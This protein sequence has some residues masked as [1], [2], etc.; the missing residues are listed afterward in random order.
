MDEP[1]TELENNFISCAPETCKKVPL[2][3]GLKNS[4]RWLLIFVLLTFVCILPVINIILF[5]FLLV[6]VPGIMIISNRILCRGLDARKRIKLGEPEYRDEDYAKPSIVLGFVMLTTVVVALAS[7]FLFGPFLK[8]FPG[9]GAYRIQQN[10]EDY[11]ELHDGK[12]PSVENWCDELRQMGIDEQ[13]KEG[14]GEYSEYSLL[15]GKD[16]LVYYGMN[17]NVKGL[18]E[19]PADMVVFFECEPGWNVHGN[20]EQVVNRWG[21]RVGVIFGDCSDEIYRAKDVP[22]LKWRPGDS[23]MIPQT[24]RII[25]YAVLGSGVAAITFWLLFKYRAGFKKYWWLSIAMSGIAVV[26]GAILGWAAELLYGYYINDSDL[27]VGWLFGI[28]AGLLVAL[29]YVAMLGVMADRKCAG[30]YVMPY[31]VASGVVA[32]VVCSC[33]VHGGLMVQ[34]QTFNFINMGAGAVFGAMAGVVLGWISSWVVMKFYQT[35]TEPAGVEN[36]IKMT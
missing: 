35:K 33:M 32:G 20:Q 3:D 16:K 8:I 5:S 26:I 14:N 2:K 17:E 34:H 21:K 10:I 23:G 12:L 31:A 1:N 22:Y 11:Q 27:K 19:V 24:D 15:G 6:L 4:Y 9:H 28:I 29:V 25:G 7:I 18:D 13:K 36:D 30:G